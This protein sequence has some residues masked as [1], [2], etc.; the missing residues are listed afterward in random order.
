MPVTTP[1]TRIVQHGVAEIVVEDGHQRHH[2]GDDQDKKDRG[3]ALAV[4][5]QVETDEIDQPEQQQQ[6]GRPIAG[7]HR[8]ELQKCAGDNE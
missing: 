1:C 2:D 7:Q 3:A 4:R 6:D 8:Y 5:L